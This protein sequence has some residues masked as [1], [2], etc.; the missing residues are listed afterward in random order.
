MGIRLPKRERVIIRMDTATIAL[1]E[2]LS[3]LSGENRSVVI[4]RAIRLLAQR[5]LPE[6]PATPVPKAGR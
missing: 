4:R 3:E 2:R 5:E 6:A 1:L